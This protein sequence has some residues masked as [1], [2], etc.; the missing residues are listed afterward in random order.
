MKRWIE[1]NIN[2][3]KIIIFFLFILTIAAG[4]GFNNLYFDSSTEAMMPKDD[5]NYKMGERAK[6]VFVDSKT[7]L[8]TAIETPDRKDLFTYK[9]FYELNE[10]VTELEEFKDFNYN[11]ENSRLETIIR[12][13]NLS[14][15]D[16][17][18][19]E[20]NES[21]VN[22]STDDIEAELDKV[23]L[24]NEDVSGTDI[25]IEDNQEH[26]IWNLSKA[27][28]AGDSSVKTVRNRRVY[29]YKK[30]KPV[31][32]EKIENVLDHEGRKELHSILRYTGLNLHDKDRLLKKRE[33]IKIAEAWET[34]YLYKSM[35]IIK[36]LNNPVSG[37]DI[38][39]TSDELKPVKLIEKNDKGDRILPVTEKDY[40]IYREKLT[41]N[42]SFESLYYSYGTGSR[43]QALALSLILRP[44]PSH[45][46][47]FN[48]FYEV[49][50]KYNN[51]DLILTQIGAPIIGKFI[52][53]FM[54]NDLFTFTPI[55]ISV[56]I[57]VFFLNFRLLRGVLLPTIC[58]IL[59]TFWTLGLMGLLNVPITV[60]VNL[61][62][63]LLLAVGSSYS[64]HIFNQ[65]LHD[66]EV[67]R[68]QGKK[69]GL[70]MSM[71]HISVTVILAGFTT[72]IGFMT[73]T[74]NRIVS[75]K[76][77][78]I[79]A[80]VGTGLAVIISIMLIPSS[81]MMMK[82]LPLKKKNGKKNTN[83]SNI[84]ISKIINLLNGISLNHSKF[85]IS[86]YSVVILVFS[87]GITRIVVESGGL[88]YFK[89]DSYIYKSDIRISQLFKG[90]NMM[91]LVVDS[92]RVDG[93]KDP[94]FLKMIEDVRDWIVKPENT[95][96]YLFLH[97][98]SFGDIIKRMNMA[99]NGENRDSFRIPDRETTVRDYLELYSG[100]DSDS[101]GRIDSFEQFVD[102]YYRYANILVK[103]G[104]YNG[105]KYSTGIN[106]AGQ[107]A[108]HNFLKQNPEAGK[109]SWHLVGEPVNFTVLSDMVIRGQLISII[110]S[111]L[112]VFF[113]ITFLFKNVRAGMISLLPISTS[114]I[115]IYGV[116]GYLDVPLDIAKALLSA[117]AIGIGVDDTI[118]MLKTIRF[119]LLKGLS[120]RD[121]ITAS[122]REAGTAIIYTSVAL[123]L[124]FSVLLFSDFKVVYYLGWLVVST[125]AATT[126]GALLLL[127]AVI[128]FFDMKLNE[129]TKWKIF[130]VFNLDFL[131]KIDNNN[132]N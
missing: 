109:Y 67:I 86:V 112:L 36:T 124:G 97:T 60:V 12:I 70:I 55:A 33:F 71:R 113:V 125:M 128:V 99:M 85:V 121:A 53:D 96:N 111:L 28:K 101:D 3:P 63:P 104:S 66:Q 76:D 83:H 14:Y 7:F 23:I 95:E 43:I 18:K 34:V 73:L 107:E 94:E 46:E 106:K 122:H 57:L 75:L 131:L 102:P 78:G 58:I 79:F 105:K 39:G 93:V 120:V 54:T 30:Y 52:K 117:V 127:P 50:E 48:Y 4:F 26:D 51:K 129:E 98:L 31:S 35:E 84:V 90:A 1:F 13:G 87:A 29:D 119:N 5:I 45:D 114:I 62:I 126:L 61:L 81:L 41:R 91:N 116:M 132:N 74:A 22:Y 123:I 89:E 82:L 103:V 25:T 24:E 115:L 92:G 37:E 100:R 32:I 56:I 40:E 38:H 10:L 19:E 21:K 108:L 15:I 44:L 88:D 77:F 20:K 130:K 68:T 11:L 17:K 64:I 80:S 49:I 27:V 9:T 110:C 59:G 16:N 69:Y 118:H 47:I 6:E 72:L 8:L 42:P 65:Y 2:H